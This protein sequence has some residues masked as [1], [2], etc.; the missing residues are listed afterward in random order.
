MGFTPYKDRHL[1]LGTELK[2]RK[3]KK[4]KVEDLSH[5][6]G[7]KMSVRIALKVIWIVFQRK[8]IPRQRIPQSSHA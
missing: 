2:K 5:S 6:D 4:R 7:S 8:P 3:V 1:L